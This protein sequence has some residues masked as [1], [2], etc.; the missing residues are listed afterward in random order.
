MVTARSYPA[1]VEG[2]LAAAEM[3]GQQQRTVSKDWVSAR[4]RAGVSGPRAPDAKEGCAGGKKGSRGLS[5]ELR[6][7]TGARYLCLIKTSTGRE[8]MASPSQN[9]HAL[10]TAENQGNERL[11]FPVLGENTGQIHSHK[12]GENPYLNKETRE[13]CGCVISPLE[14]SPGLSR[15]WKCT[16]GSIEIHTFRDLPTVSR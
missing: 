2:S 10:E 1:S 6:K 8:E 13:R 5:Q 9:R 15:Q 12:L 4:G 3:G 16:L 7:E 14:G 11:I